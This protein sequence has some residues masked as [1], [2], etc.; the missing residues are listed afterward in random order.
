MSSFPGA[1]AAAGP[2]RTAF[3]GADAQE[4]AQWLARGGISLDRYGKGPAKSLDQLWCVPWQ[5]QE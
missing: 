5:A 3:A 4:L 2:D 1:A